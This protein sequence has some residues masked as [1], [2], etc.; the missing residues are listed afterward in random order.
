MANTFMSED[1]YL[2][3]SSPMSDHNELLCYF[4]HCLCGTERSCIAY[5]AIWEHCAEV[6]DRPIL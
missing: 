4:L 5:V 1:Q 6:N 3:T 2:S